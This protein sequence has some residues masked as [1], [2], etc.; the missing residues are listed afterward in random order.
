MVRRLD[1]RCRTSGVWWMES[2]RLGARLSGAEFLV[3]A[4]LIVVRLSIPSPLHTPADVK[5]SSVLG[6][7]DPGDRD[8]TVA[9]VEARRCVR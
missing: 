1:Y 3:G 2:E 9:S 7:F 8:V 6:I 4:C 5:F